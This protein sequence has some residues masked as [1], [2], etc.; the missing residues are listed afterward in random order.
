MMLFLM[1]A[2]GDTLVGRM[3]GSGAIFLYDGTPTPWGQL[4]VEPTRMKLS[5]FVC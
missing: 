1:G 4:L 2:L 3:G 5:N